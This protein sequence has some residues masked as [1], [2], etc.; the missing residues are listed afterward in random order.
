MAAVVVSGQEG[1]R[2]YGGGGDLWGTNWTAPEVHFICQGA[3]V[4]QVVIV[5]GLRFRWHSL[6]EV[7]LNQVTHSNW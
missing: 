4:D 1:A 7:A 3:G 5:T 2:E 6:K